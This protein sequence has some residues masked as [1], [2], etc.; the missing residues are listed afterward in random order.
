VAI[1]PI[2]KSETVVQAKDKIRF[3]AT[4]S[5]VTDE[6]SPITQVEIRPELEADFIDITN[7][8]DG[9]IDPELWFLDWA[10]LTEGQKV[11]T[12]KVTAGALSEE[13]SIGIKVVTE[14][15]D[16]LFSTDDDLRAKEHDIEKWIPEGYSS[17]NHIHRQAQKNILDWLDEQRITKNDGSR[18]DAK[19]LVD[20][21][22]VRRLSVYITL[23]MI[24][25]SI[26][27]QVGDVFEEKRAEYQ[28]LETQAKN[29]RTWLK[30]DTTGDG[31][32]DKVQDLRTFR[33]VRR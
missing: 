12:L 6:P 21:E 26:S 15:D 23:R 29:A 24:F 2:L 9:Y 22:Q 33:M 16:C 28:R 32:A 20:K 27:N 25:G 14:E 17:W 8:V 7:E 4:R 5:F 30:L 1:F 13:K 31:L 3:L 10:Y 18:F 19:D 11:V